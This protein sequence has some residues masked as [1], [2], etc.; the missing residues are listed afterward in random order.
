MKKK[1]DGWPV[2]VKALRDA[3][4]GLEEAAR[5]TET[6]IS[7]TYGRFPRPLKKADPLKVY[8]PPREKGERQPVDLEGYVPLRDIA[9]LVHYIADM[10]ER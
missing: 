3:S 7:E 1:P 4:M 6:Q 5:Q 10:L 2:L 9:G 8:F